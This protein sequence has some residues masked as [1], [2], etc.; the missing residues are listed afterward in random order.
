MQTSA[1]TYSGAIFDCDTHLFEKADAWTRYLPEKFKE[2]WSGG[3]RKDE[4]GQWRLYMGKRR[5]MLGE[6]HASGDGSIPRPGSLKAYLKALKNGD[7]FDMRASK[8]E[9]MLSHGARLRK[10]DEFGVEGCIVFI[11]EHVSMFGYLDDDIE[12]A[13]AVHHAYNQYL[14]DEWQFNVDERIYTTPV[15]T[16]GDL[17]ASIRETDWIIRNGARIVIMPVGP[18]PVG[19]SPADVYYDP[20]WAR[21]NEAG[22]RIAYH[23]AEAPYMHA[24]MRQ[25]GEVP[26][27][28]RIKQSAWV[29]LNAYR[30]VPIIQTLSSLIFYNFFERF[31]NIK[32]ISAEN[33]AEWV[34]GLLNDMDKCRGMARN[35]DWPCGQLKRR[36]SELFKQN[37]YVVAYPEDD[38]E[39]IVA[40]VGSSNWLVMGSDYPHAEGVPTPRDFF[41]E[42]CG[43]LTPQQV[44]GIMYDNGRRFLPRVV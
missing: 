11:G 28:S 22:V 44:Q 24:M 20:V 27:Q 15:L 40:E 7:A 8:T 34:P 5:V 29:W 33:G 12:A 41:A 21:L 16:L 13:N 14:L 31:P 17:D 2:E 3:H 38:L 39:K 23:I 25:W 18:T 35:A 4:D 43:G 30:T 42:A 10:M 6:G 36:P 32:V 37:V 26:L 9:D 19:R 1:Q